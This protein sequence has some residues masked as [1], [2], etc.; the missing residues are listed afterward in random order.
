LLPLTTSDS[1]VEGEPTI[2]DD[3]QPSCIAVCDR[4][5]EC[6]AFEVD[7][8]DEYDQKKHRFLRLYCESVDRVLMI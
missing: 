3:F 6:T 1:A 5:G 7:R 4:G 8:T 2:M